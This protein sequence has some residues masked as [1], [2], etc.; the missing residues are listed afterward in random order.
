MSFR[1]VFFLCCVLALI[2]FAGFGIC[3]LHLPSSACALL[4][5][6]LAV[7]LLPLAWIFS[8]PPRPSMDD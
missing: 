6:I 5:G 4:T 8:A 1:R 3:V 2:L 7:V